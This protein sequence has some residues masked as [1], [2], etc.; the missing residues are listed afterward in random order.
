MC[1]KVEMILVQIELR[2]RSY[3]PF[4][5]FCLVLCVQVKVEDVRH[6]PAI[7]PESLELAE[8]ARGVHRSLCRGV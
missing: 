4:Q 5:I 3:T 1:Q 7:N 2:I 8:N 6:P